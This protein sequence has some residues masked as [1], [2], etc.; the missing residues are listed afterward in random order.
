MTFRVRK[1]SNL[2]D[3]YDDRTSIDKDYLRRL[4]IED[5]WQVDEPDEFGV[6]R[7]EKELEDELE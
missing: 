4:L 1:A 5:G 2:V 3:F 6:M 7:A